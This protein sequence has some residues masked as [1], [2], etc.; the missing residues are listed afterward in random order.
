MLYQFKI[1]RKV[2]RVI[3]WFF[4]EETETIYCNSII[5]VNEI[6]EK[7]DKVFELSGYS[8]V[9]YTA[10]DEMNRLI[11]YYDKTFRDCSNSEAYEHHILQIVEHI[12]NSNWC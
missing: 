12:D 5:E 2:K 8:Y 1:I 9:P 6:L 4:G 11:N 10:K 7:D 3:T